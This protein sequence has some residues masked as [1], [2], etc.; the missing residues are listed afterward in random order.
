M[1][2]AIDYV[3]RQEMLE[4]QA[5]SLLLLAEIRLAARHPGLARQAATQALRISEARGHAYFTDRSREL[6]RRIRGAPDARPATV[7]VDQ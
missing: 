6:L 1:R 7:L 3:F 2:T 4:E 5:E